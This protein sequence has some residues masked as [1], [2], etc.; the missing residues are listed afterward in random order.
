MHLLGNT[1]TGGGAGYANETIQ[2][3]AFFDNNMKKGLLED[4][5]KVL[6]LGQGTSERLHQS[7]KRI[8]TKA[9]NRLGG[10]VKQALTE[11]KMSSIRKRETE[12]DKKKTYRGT[13]RVTVLGLVCEKMAERVVC[14]RQEEEDRR[15]RQEVRNSP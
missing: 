5:K 15:E 9:R 1:K 2:P 7:A 12:A 13:D 8:S 4:L 11:V 6:D 3:C 14:D 10:K